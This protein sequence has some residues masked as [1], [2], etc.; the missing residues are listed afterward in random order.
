LM[1]ATPSNFRHKKKTYF[2]SPENCIISLWGSQGVSCVL[3]KNSFKK[4]NENMKIF[5]ENKASFFLLSLIFYNQITQHFIL[6]RIL[7]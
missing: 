2:H 1:A 6:W 4:E 5:S 7:I 3:F